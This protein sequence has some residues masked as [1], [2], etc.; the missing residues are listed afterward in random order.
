[1]HR[2]FLPLTF[3]VLVGMGSVAMAQNP[4]QRAPRQQ[5]PSQQEDSANGQAVTVIGC[6]AKGTAPD[7]F[8]ITE[9]KSGQKLA[10]GGPNQLEK[11]L[12]Q[13]IQLTGTMMNKGG[14]KSFQPETVKPVSPMC[15]SS[16]GQ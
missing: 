5:Q 11:Y 4:S 16:K 3:S 12:N 2:I 13:T 6:L 8:V 7:E 9:N 15:E 1:M 14:E 10:F